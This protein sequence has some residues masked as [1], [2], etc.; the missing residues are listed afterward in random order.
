[1]KK[2]F[3][4]FRFISSILAVAGVSSV[5]FAQPARAELD[6]GS[7]I[8]NGTGVF[9]SLSSGDFSLDNIYSI[10]GDAANISNSLGGASIGDFS[11]SLGDLS[12]VGDFSTGGEAFGGGG[13]DGGGSPDYSSI[14]GFG[15]TEID[16]LGNSSDYA[17]GLSKE[18]WGKIGKSTGFL[19]GLIGN[20]SL[21]GK[22]DSISGILG[23][24]GILDPNELAGEEGS[25]GA[26]LGGSDDEIAPSIADEMANAKTPIDVYQAATKKKNLNPLNTFNI[27]QAVL[28]K[29]GQEFTISQAKEQSAALALS[30][31]ASQKAA[32]YVGNAAKLSEAQEKSV[33]SAQKI[34]DAGVKTKQTLDAVH[35]LIGLGGVQSGQLSMVTGGLTLL[36]AGQAQQLKQGEANAAIDKINGDGIRMVAVQ[37]AAATKALSDIG[38]DIEAQTQQANEEKF[39]N[40]SLATQSQSIMRVP[41]LFKGEAQ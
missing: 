21:G 28:G 37:S 33:K 41:T 13:F 27:S 38:S 2:P 19:K 4:S 23:A 30:Q 40:Y 14:D 35:S 36:S 11:S 18:T 29:P 17:L 39:S 9:Q 3:T 32:E 24:W 22:V 25:S 20:S 7:L 31:S 16:G 10:A 12:S 5:I 34:V 6:I 26:I 15:S 8:G 1:V